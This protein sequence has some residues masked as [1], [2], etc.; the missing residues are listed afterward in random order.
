MEIGIDRL[1]GQLCAA[2]CITVID[3]VHAMIRNVDIRIPYNGR[4]LDLVGVRIDGQNH[5][6]IAS[7]GRPRFCIDPEKRDVRN[8]CHTIEIVGQSGKLLGFYVEWRRTF[9]GRFRRSGCTG[10]TG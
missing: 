5:D 3:L 10:R 1:Q 8:S 6:R 9:R 4:K 7:A 2:E